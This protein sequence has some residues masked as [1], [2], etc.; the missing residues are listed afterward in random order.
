MMLG[1]KLRDHHHV[2]T[3][4]GLE[5]DQ[6]LGEVPA[7]LICVQLPDRAHSLFLRETHDRAKEQ[8]NPRAE[9]C[10]PFTESTLDQKPRVHGSEA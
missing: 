9:A 5:V 4:V 1:T 6:Q 3:V 7:L 2:G 10:N 8:T